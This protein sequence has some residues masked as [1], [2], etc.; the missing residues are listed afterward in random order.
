MILFYIT[1]VL[2]NNSIIL[3]IEI[4]SLIIFTKNLIRTN[5]I[6]LRDVKK[7]N[8]YDRT[9]DLSRFVTFTDN[10]SMPFR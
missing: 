3:I 9:N 6:A 7:K 5:L 1:I 2:Y 8:C 10:R 4:V